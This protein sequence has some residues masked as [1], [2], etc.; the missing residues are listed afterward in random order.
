MFLQ[1]G[2][3]KKGGGK[4]E[5][6]SNLYI[7]Y[8]CLGRKGKRERGEEDRK[9]ITLRMVNS[10]CMKEEGRNR[11]ASKGDHSFYTVEEKEGK[12]FFSLVQ[13]RG[14]GG[15]LGYGS[16]SLRLDHMRKGGKKGS[17]ICSYLRLRRK[18]KKGREE[19]NKRGD[20]GYMG[21]SIHAIHRKKKRNGAVIS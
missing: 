7:L 19:K 1:F 20:K 5:P 6:W 12:T 4:T 17:P 14:K 3:K 2:L 16:L 21:S 15:E 9:G 11:R 13:T 10:P 8:G 18:G